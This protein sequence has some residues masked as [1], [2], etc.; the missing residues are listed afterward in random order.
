M[1]VGRFEIILPSTGYEK[2]VFTLLTVFSVRP[3]LVAL[4]INAAGSK[5]K[6]VNGKT[7]NVI[8]VRAI[9]E[10]TNKKNLKK[11]HRRDHRGEGGVEGHGGSIVK[12]PTTIGHARF[13]IIV[14]IFFIVLEIHR[15]RCY[16][17]NSQICVQIKKK[18]YQISMPVVCSARLQWGK[19]KNKFTNIVTPSAKYLL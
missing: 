7:M 10:K 11:Y 19:N 14:N 18:K 17:P 9:H 8:F 13:F 3:F 16:A 5:S 15:K 4:L 6:N 12:R 2:I 1:P